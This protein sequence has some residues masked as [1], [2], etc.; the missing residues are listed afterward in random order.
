VYAT[1]LGQPFHT[2]SSDMVG[3]AQ[4]LISLLLLLLARA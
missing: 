4:S 3:A 2:D 1:S